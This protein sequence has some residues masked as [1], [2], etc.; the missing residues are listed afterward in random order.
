[1]LGKVFKED[2]IFRIDHYLG[3]E[4]VQNILAF[5]FSNALF[6]PIWDRKYIDN[7]QITVAEN[8]GVEH[9]GS[10]LR[11][12]RG[13]ARHGS[14]PSITDPVHDRDGADGQL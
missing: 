2:Q 7:V 13:S 6:E 12:C 5:R 14:K 11:A 8:I 10:L 3:K 1:M 9:R 4:T